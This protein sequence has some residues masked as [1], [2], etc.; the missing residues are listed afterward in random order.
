MS[1]N[2]NNESK[3]PR[4][5]QMGDE[6]LTE[7][8][9]DE[10]EE[11]VLNEDDEGDGDE[12]EMEEGDENGLEEIIEEEGEEEE[13]EEDVEVEKIEDMSVFTFGGHTDSVYAVKVSLNMIMLRNCAQLLCHYFY[14]TIYIDIDT[15]N[16][17]WFRC[18]W[19]GG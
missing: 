10:N 2:D 4:T 11:M 7:V 15:P 3:K 5:I 8:P 12:E 18:H 14:A 17:T 9:D 1:S 6:I 13:V 16:Y 19:R